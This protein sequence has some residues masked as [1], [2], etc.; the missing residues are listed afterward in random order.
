MRCAACGSSQSRVLS[1]RMQDG[2][3]VRRRECDQGH[4]FSTAEIPL[5]TAKATRRL[6]RANAQIDRNR[7][8]YLRN[9]KIVRMAEEGKLY[10]VIAAEFS[11]NETTISY[12]LSKHAPH[13]LRKP[14]KGTKT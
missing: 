7:E 6:A 2:V 9:L 11:V 3:L 14:R 12:V 4:R 13:L 8:R 10:K 1:T 5:K